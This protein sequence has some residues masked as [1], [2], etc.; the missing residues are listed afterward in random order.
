MYWG[1]VVGK[2]QQRQESRLVTLRKRQNNLWTPTTNH[3]KPQ[4]PPHVSSFSSSLKRNNYDWSLITPPYTL[5]PENSL[6]YMIAL[7]PT[8]WWLYRAVHPVT[9]QGQICVTLC[10][11]SELMR[12]TWPSFIMKGKSHI[13][14]A[15]VSVSGVMSNSCT[16][17]DPAALW[18]IAH[19]YLN[20]QG[21]KSPLFPV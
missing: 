7:H 18:M 9:S 11:C 10:V 15:E 12:R 19:I 3:E 13:N 4:L 8:C 5:A 20:H 17:S 6:I 21:P 1:T 16:A 14:L 2:T